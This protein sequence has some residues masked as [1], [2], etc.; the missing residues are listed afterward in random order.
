MSENRNPSTRW[1]LTACLFGLFLAVLA[2]SR[3]AAAATVDT[4]Y[5]TVQWVQV[6]ESGR[7]GFRLDES[8][9]VY[10][11]CKAS[12][13]AACQAIL[14]TAIST[15]REVKVFYEATGNRHLPAP[16]QTYEIESLRI[17]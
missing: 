13:R 3:P 15:A 6:D 9:V 5:R 1:G 2:V 7:I 4:G 10:Y 8:V 16:N 12:Q 17:R 11:R 14:L